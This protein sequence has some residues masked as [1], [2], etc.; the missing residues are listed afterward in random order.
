MSAPVAPP[1]APGSEVF[2]EMIRQ[3]REIMSLQEEAYENFLKRQRQEQ[4][5][6]VVLMEKLGLIDIREHLDAEFDL[7]AQLA[8][9][10]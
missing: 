10:E 9:K 3:Q 4:H 2:A 7:L 1:S 5:N 6:L 8:T